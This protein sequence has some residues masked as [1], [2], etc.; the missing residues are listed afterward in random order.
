MK[1]GEQL[2]RT[3]VTDRP[4]VRAQL[5][6]ATGLRRVVPNGSRI[7]VV[8]QAPK[9]LAGP[10]ARHSRHGT[11]TVL[12]DGR[13]VARI[14][15]LLAQRLPAVSPITLAA[16]FL[17]R[18]TTIFVLVMLLLVLGGTLAARRRRTPSAPARA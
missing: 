4:G 9:Q 5:I 12:V 8:I 13:P 14:A 16:R 10:L 2:A 6:A 15:L 18:G 7:T 11:A 1:A 17:T 3:T